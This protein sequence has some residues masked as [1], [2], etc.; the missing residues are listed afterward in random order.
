MEACGFRD[1]YKQIQKAGAVVLGVS[2]DTPEKQKKF[3]EKFDLPFTLLADTDKAVAKAYDVLKEKNMYGRK[4]IGIE[5]TTFMI[6]PEGKIDR[7]FP[8]VKA[9]GHAEE[10]L[11]A[12]KSC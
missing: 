7:V 2:A 11:A 1:A 8:K 4:V 6:G 3:K 12:M 5:R 10:V 9:E